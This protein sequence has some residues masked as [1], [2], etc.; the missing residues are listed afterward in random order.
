M[1]NRYKSKNIWDSRYHGHL[2]RSDARVHHRIIE[3]VNRLKF[4]N[5]TIR[6][7]DCAGGSGALIKRIKDNLN[8]KGFECYLVSNDY[9]NQLTY[10]QVDEKIQLDLNYSFAHAIEGEKFDI[11]LA[12]EIIEH[13]NNPWLFVKELYQLVE[14]DGLI[15]ISTPNSTSLLDKLSYVVGSHPFYFGEKGYYHSGGHISIV[16]DWK[17]ILIA[18]ASKLKLIDTD[19]SLSI[20]AYLGYWSSFK[21]LLFLVANMIFIKKYNFTAINIY[22]L[23]KK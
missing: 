2:V 21:L 5:K 16:E 19:K 10:E 13:L 14:N 8:E 17:M 18:N 11:I 7:L 3:K 20:F 15:Y 12:I 22:T 9:E 6:I 23:K 1:F 4:E